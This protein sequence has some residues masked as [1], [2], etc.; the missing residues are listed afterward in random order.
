MKHQRSL[1][2]IQADL[3]QL[4]YFSPWS[5]IWKYWSEVS[6]LILLFTLIWIKIS[7][8][9]SPGPESSQNFH[10]ITKA[11]FH[12]FCEIPIFSLTQQLSVAFLCSYSPERKLI[13]R[14]L[15]DCNS[16]SVTY[17]LRLCIVY[18]LVSEVSSYFSS[19][20]SIY[21]LKSSMNTSQASM[22]RV[23]AVF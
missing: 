17:K 10:R 11:V 9:H 2:I 1:E 21:S 14:I 15:L 16:I 4:S 3:E 20:K 7:W 8:D 12:C 18:K 6:I 19:E 5:K 13:L 22:T 23:L